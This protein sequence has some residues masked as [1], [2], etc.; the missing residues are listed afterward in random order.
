[1]TKPQR[2]HLMAELWPNAC[3]T[4]GWRENDREKRLEVLSAAV[5]RKLDSA[6]DLDAHED[7]SRVKLRLLRLADDVDAAGHDAG[8]Q[9]AA[10]PLPKAPLGDH[11]SAI[12][13][14]KIRLQL[15]CLVI[16]LKPTNAASQPAPLNLQP[17]TTYARSILSDISRRAGYETAAQFEAADFDDLLNSLDFDRLDQLMKT[18]DRCLHNKR[19]G[20][21]VKAGHTMHDMFTAADIKCH[22]KECCAKAIENERQARLAQMNLPRIPSPQMSKNPARSDAFSIP[23]I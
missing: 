10:A 20:L 8:R 22:C 4:Q 14:G 5:G 3:A 7:F 2:I 19:S 23:S 6:G 11:P 12:R 21:R 9:T 1:M 15:R 18:I 13:R 17:A 16:Y